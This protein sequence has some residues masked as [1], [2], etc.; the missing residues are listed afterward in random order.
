LYGKSYQWETNQSGAVGRFEPK[1]LTQ[2]ADEL[3]GDV[4]VF[5]SA[6]AKNKTLADAVRHY[7]NDLFGEHGL[8][9]VDADNRQFKSLFTGVI[10]DDLFVQSAKKLVEEK[11]QQ[12]EAQGYHPQVFARDVNFFYLDKNIRQRIENSAQTSFCVRCIRK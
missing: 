12:L 6:Y 1:G 3:P 2:L 9:V 8:I 10:R 7:V 4:S 5:K 11:N